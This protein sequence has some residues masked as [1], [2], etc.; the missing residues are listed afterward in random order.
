MTFLKTFEV[1]KQEKE[2]ENDLFSMQRLPEEK[3]AEG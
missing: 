3:S 2:K 1:L